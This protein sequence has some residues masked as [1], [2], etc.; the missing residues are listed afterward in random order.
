MK[1]LEKVVTSDGILSIVSHENMLAL[2]NGDIGYSCIYTDNKVYQPIFI[3]VQKVAEAYSISHTIHN[4]VILG[5]GCCT[6]PRFLI[7]RFNNTI[8]ID[9][10][11]YQPAIVELTRKYFLNGID[12]DK[13]NLINDDAYKYIR[14]T[15]SLYDF[16]YIDLFVG[17]MKS[18][19]SHTMTF[20]SDVANHSTEQA[21]IVINGYHSSLE[22]CLHLS[23][24][25]KACFSR[26]YILRDESETCY[27]VF[28]NDSIN[29]KELKQYLLP[30]RVDLRQI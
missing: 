10:V 4:A 2:R 11:E 15:S 13:L 23:Q 20:L 7:K 17:G 22:Q 19:K 3:P 5:G 1:I 9:S 18:G 16:I 12:T 29:E 27:V 25:G 28:T 26:S 30:A 14:D 21:A 8:R 6:I 24:R